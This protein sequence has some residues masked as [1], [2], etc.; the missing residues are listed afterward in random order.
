MFYRSHVTRFFKGSKIN[1]LPE[2]SG[3]STVF[4]RGST[5]F[6]RGSSVFSRGSTVFS[7]G[8]TVFSRAP[9]SSPGLHR[10]LRGST[11][12]SRGSSVF[13]RGSSVFSRAPASSPRAPPS[14]PGAP[15]SSP[16]A[17]ASS[18]GAPA[19]S[20]RAPPSSPGL[21]RLLPGLHRLLPGLHRLLPG[22]QR[23]LPGLHRLLPGSTVFSPGSSVFTAGSR[24][25]SSNPQMPQK[26]KTVKAQQPGAE[27]EASGPVVRDRH[28]AL[29]ITVHAKPGSKH[30]AITD[31]SVEA[32]GVSIAAPPTDGEA[33]TE[34]IR[35]L[36]QVLDLKKSHISLHKG[37][38]SR[39]KLVR[40]DSSLSVEE[41]LRRL[42]GDART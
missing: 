1:R 35:F 34:L 23:L 7:R 37:S 17:P 29:T 5:V 21:H 16:G 11:V 14:S 12:F 36:A 28:G 38:R 10:L 4:S 42:R 27:P 41:V 9:P 15:P 19:S 40:V 2:P 30:S 22:L 25:F 18:P 8:S 32:V 33:N 6:S 3:P 26:Q 31:V 20:P 13:S 39:D 24:R